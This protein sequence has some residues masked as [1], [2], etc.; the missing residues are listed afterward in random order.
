MGKRG[1][2]KQ[3]TRLRIARGDPSKEGEHAGEPMPPIGN[4]T[5]PSYV[6]GK[7]REKWDELIPIL[8]S[9][10]VMT[11]ADLETL[12]R[13]C[14]VWEQWCRYLDQMRR[15][16]DVLVIRDKDGKVKY[17]QSA[18][19]A[20]MFV[21]LGQTLLRIEQEF[22]LT[23]SARASMEVSYGETNEDAVLRKYT[24]PGG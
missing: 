3:P 18:P 14:V 16:L 5:P 1:P 4:L 24:R 19:A 11:Q 22:G 6:I 10:K 9:M 12:A 23:P 20:T 13:Y 8:V 15:G 21:K 2:R 17:M 7:S